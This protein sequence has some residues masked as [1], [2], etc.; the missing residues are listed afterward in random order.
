MS[1]FN[2]SNILKQVNEVYN[3]VNGIIKDR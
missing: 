2:P 3:N 1:V